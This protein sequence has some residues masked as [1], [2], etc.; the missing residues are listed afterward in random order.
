METIEDVCNFL[1]VD[2]KNSVKALLMNVDEEFVCFFVRGDRELN[3]TKA[4]KLLGAKEINFANDEL[5]ATS[6][7]VPGFTGPIDLNCKIVIDNELLY[8]KNFC[9]GAN[10][11]DYHYINANVSDFKYDVVGD[12]TNVMDGDVCPK[13]GGKLYFKKGI[14]IGNLFKLGTKYAEKLGLTYLDENNESQVVVMGCYGIGPGR[15]LASIIEQ[16]NDENG[17]ILPMNI[18]PYEVAIVLIDSNDEKQSEFANKLYDELKNN[19]IDVLLDD[20]NERPGVKFKDMDLIGIPL[21]INVGKKINEGFVEF[22]ERTNK[23]FELVDINEIAS[24]TISYV[25][26]SLK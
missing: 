2:T 24:K 25:K 21:R 12:I 8:M 11:Q 7:A 15:I 19:G 3:T 18:A 14:E 10:K 13:C 23:E 6:N 16:N 4:C 17:M 9:C 22:K 1:N 20:R 5:I 26:N